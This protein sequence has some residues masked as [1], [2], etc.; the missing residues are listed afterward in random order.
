M[1]LFYFNLYGRGED[2]R[3][4]LHKAGA[5]YEDVRVEFPEWPDMKKNETDK[6]KYGTMPVLEKDGK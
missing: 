6:F 4:L 3:I 5:E 1:K 2:I